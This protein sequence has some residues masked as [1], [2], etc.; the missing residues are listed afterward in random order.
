VLGCRMRLCLLPL[1]LLTGTAA[2]EAQARAGG[3][4]LQPE[5]D[6]NAALTKNV[7][8]QNLYN[9]IIKEVFNSMTRIMGWSL[10]ALVLYGNLLSDGRRKRSVDVG[11]EEEG[12]VVRRALVMAEEKGWL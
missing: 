2:V 6:W 12:N 1:L 5:A 11:E 7:A 9:N 8:R 4:E 10:I 3:V